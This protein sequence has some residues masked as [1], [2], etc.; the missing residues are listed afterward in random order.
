M[1]MISA[2]DVQLSQQLSSAAATL[3][4]AG[5]RNCSVI[6]VPSAAAGSTTALGSN[7]VQV[8]Y[9]QY[10]Q[11]MTAPSLAASS[12]SILNYF[13]KIRKKLIIIFCSLILICLD[14]L[15]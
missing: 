6:E 14:Y 11:L 9:E 4:P 5:L 10:Q 12:T 15:N 1:S 8:T 2:N 13:T 3:M 7:T